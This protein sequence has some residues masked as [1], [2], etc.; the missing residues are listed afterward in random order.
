MIIRYKVNISKDV[1]EEIYS[2]VRRYPWKKIKKLDG[3]IHGTNYK[4]LKSISKY[5]V[6]KYNWKKQEDKINS[7]PNFITNVNGLKIHFIKEKSNNPKSK[8]LL[9][10]HGWPGSIIEFLE[11]H[12]FEHETFLYWGVISPNDLYLDDLCSTWNEKYSNFHYIPVVSEPNTSSN[13]QGRIGLV[14][15]AALQDF[16]DLSNTNVYVSG[17]AGMVYATLDSFI[18][19]GMP[20]ENMFSD[21]F[22]FAPR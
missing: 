7:F 10:L 21:V 15:E 17:S 3:W 6:S 19:H 2:K 14:G 18:D 12:G 11:P 13:W 1:L 22:S 8:P 5:W 4:Y 16:N 9:L 20:E